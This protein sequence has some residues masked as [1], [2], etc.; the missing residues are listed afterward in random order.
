MKLAEIEVT[1]PYLDLSEDF[2][3]KSIPEPLDAPKLV[4]WSE[5]AAKLI[6]FDEE[7]KSD[8]KLLAFLNGEYLLKGSEPFSMAYAGH[9]FG[10]YNPWLGDGR[11]H[12][13]GT[14]NGWQLQL[15]GS[16]ETIY[17]RGA[18]GRAALRSSIREFLMSEAMHHLGIP[19]TRALA[20]ITS[21]TKIV[22]NSI[23]NAAILLRLSPSWLRFG[24]FEYFYYTKEYTKLQELA[25]YAITES[26]RD[27]IGDE[28]RYFKMFEAIVHSSAKVVAQWQGVGFCHGVIN[29][30]NTSLLGLTM[31]Y[32]PF[33]MLD[34]FNY[35]YIC[36]HT[37][38]V[39][40]Y[41]YGAQPNIL[42]WNLT[43]LAKALSPIIQSSRTQALLDDFGS[44]IYPDA[45]MA[46][47]RKK[48]GLVLVLSED[49][50]LIQE[51]VGALQDAYVDY[52]LFFRTLCHYDG[53]REALYDIAMEPVAIH[54]WLELYDLRLAKEPLTQPER[55]ASM[56]C[57]NP[58]YV[59]KNYMLEDAIHKAQRGDFSMVEK[60]L[61]IAQ[62]PYDELDEFE[63]FEEFSKETPELYK[64][65]GL[66]CSS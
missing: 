26:F 10:H 24:S 35:N 51:L 4:A 53:N 28:D 62:H 14:I 12:H 52:T 31:D 13:L 30:D 57:I 42:Y 56:L 22:R 3:R 37:D 45:Y 59:L 5:D 6:G 50:E 64:N 41:S 63:E 36:N 9:Q 7:T 23:E 25:D 48:L 58:K 49:I 18:D 38:R 46:L 32:G 43:M 29:T 2:Y 15:K 61:F 16:G 11:V 55:K 19:T 40:R 66:A 60:L 33:S 27:F 47:M 34:D 17:A 1:N 21:E 54:N 44:F 20:L 8:A 65:I 39:G